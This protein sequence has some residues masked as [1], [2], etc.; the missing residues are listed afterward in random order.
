MGRRQ[1][2]CGITAFYRMSV[3]DNPSGKTCGFA[4]SPC[5]G[6]ALADSVVRPYK[7]HPYRGGFRGFHP[8]GC[9]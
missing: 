3:A 4:T 5:T 7:A 6:E 2:S 1:H 8:L 9:I